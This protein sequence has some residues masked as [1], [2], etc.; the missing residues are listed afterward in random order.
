MRPSCGRDLKALSKKGIEALTISLINSFANGDHEQKVAQI[1][2][3]VMPDIPISLS[4]EI[5]PEMQEYERTITTVANSY[6]RP[7]VQTYVHNLG[8]QLQK[9]MKHGPAARPAI[10][11]WAGVGEGRRGLPGEPADER[12]RR[13]ASPARSGW[14]SSPA[15]RI[16]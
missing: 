10:R 11:R 2:K 8:K 14:P 12:A 6:V 7:K 13:A 15:S 3:E 9:T 4:S 16:C 1:A 5:V